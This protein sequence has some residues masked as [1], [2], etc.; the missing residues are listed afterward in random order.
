MLVSTKYW[1]TCYE[2]RKDDGASKA[3]SVVSSVLLLGAQRYIFSFIEL[4]LSQV[5][6]ALQKAQRLLSIFR[7]QPEPPLSVQEFRLNNHA[8]S[9]WEINVYSILKQHLLSVEILP[10]TFRMRTRVRTL[11]FS[12]LAA[13]R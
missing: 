5:P 13:D 8:E 9:A 2:L 7:S 10:V 12:F 11:S 4:R 3:I 6:R 1:R